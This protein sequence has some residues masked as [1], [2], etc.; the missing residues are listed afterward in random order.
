MSRKNIKKMSKND[1]LVRNYTWW[2][3]YISIKNRGKNKKRPQKARAGILRSQCNFYWSA[4]SNI[5]ASFF[6]AR[7]IFCIPENAV[8]GVKA[9][10]YVSASSVK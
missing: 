1:K 5:S 3:M 9:L 2:K 7:A 4:F 6:A 8:S 10:R